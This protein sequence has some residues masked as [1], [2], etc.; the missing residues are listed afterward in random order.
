MSILSLEYLLFTALTFAAYYLFPVKKRWW[1]LLMVSTLFYLL[2]GWRGMA[3]LGTV[4][5]VTWGGALGIHA[6]AARKKARQGRLLLALVLFS[7]IGAMA[8]FKYIGAIN[9]LI[10]AGGSGKT[11]PARAW[12]PPL[13]LSW[14]TFQSAGYVI[15]V[16]RG[17]FE[18]EKNPC[19][20]LL[21][22]SFFPQMA[23]GPIS[24]WQQLSPQLVEGHRLQPQGVAS[25]FLL[26]IWGYFKKLVIADRLA[27]VTAYVT[28]GAKQPGWLI[29]MGAGFYMVQLYADFSGGMDVIR[30][31]ARTFGIDMAENFRRPFFAASVSEYWRRWHISLGSW[32]RSYLLYPLTTSHL[33]LAVGHAACRRLGKKMGRLIPSA[34]AT[35]IVFLCIGLW[36]GANWNAVLYGLYFGLVMSG[37][38]LLQPLFRS[39]KGRMHVQ[40]GRSRLG[41]L[42]WIR[43]W[44]LVMLPQF[45]AFTNGPR[46]AFS[47]MRQSICGWA[48]AGFVETMTA[49]MTPLEWLVALAAMLL[50]LGVD[51]LQERGIDVCGHLAAK[52]APLRFLA[53]IALILSIVVL[54]CY[55][56][57][58]DSAAFLYAQF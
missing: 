10:T 15:D 41:C 17:K 34:L 29:L 5:A 27:A 46:Q 23:Q 42:R 33:G 16:Y 32:F 3:Y 8:F 52:G 31:T 26:M 4:A 54:G 57:G 50:L 9:A 35:I 6:L 38:I 36:H 13:G 19:K 20:Y 25:G 43:T 37:A 24:T 51:L 49:V 39:V 2:A 30:G 56:D 45:F 47:L 40:D 12:I 14:F 48:S 1:L 22:V 53:L 55:G 11:L 18:P 7:V 28:S 44:I 58:F 21:F